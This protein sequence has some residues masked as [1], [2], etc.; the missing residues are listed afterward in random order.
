M[1]QIP[2]I[3]IDGRAKPLSRS[4]D[5]RPTVAPEENRLLS[6]ESAPC[7]SSCFHGFLGDNFKRSGESV[8]NLNRAGAIA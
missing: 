8:A 1:R 5:K 7:N 4:E 2:R 3:C 6:S